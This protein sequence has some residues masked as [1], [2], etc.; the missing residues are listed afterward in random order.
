MPVATVDIDVSDLRGIQRLAGAILLQAIEDIRLRS[1][2][3]R[4]E[5]LHW[6]QD[7]GNVQFSFVFCCRMLERDPD[8]VRKFLQHRD[9][10]Q[11]LFAAARGAALP[12]SS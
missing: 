8:E 9:V 5:A 4:E 11:W 7:D 1:G 10:L 12:A 6:V 2:R 3:T